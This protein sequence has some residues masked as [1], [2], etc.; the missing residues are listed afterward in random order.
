MTQI[1]HHDRAAVVTIAI[2]QILASTLDPDEQ[3]LQI[4]H[5]LRDE[6][7]DSEQQIAADRES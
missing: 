5:L 6:F 4:E 1:H 7:A 3:Q 2:R